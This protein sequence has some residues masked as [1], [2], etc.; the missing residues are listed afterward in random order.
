MTS[1]FPC[2]SSVEVFLFSDPQRR[3][4]KPVHIYL[5][6]ST[7]DRGT[8]GIAAFVAAIC[9]LPHVSVLIAAFMGSTETLQSLAETVLARYT[10]ATLA[11]LVLVVLF[12]TI[13]GTIAAWLVT[14]TEF[15]GRRLLEIA[16]V[17]PLAFPAYVLAYAYTHVLD[18]P[19]IWS[20][21]ASTV[22]Y[23]SWKSIAGNAA[24]AIY[25][26]AQTLLH[27]KA[28]YCCGL[29][30]AIAWARRSAHG[31][32]GCHQQ[33]GSA[34]SSVAGIKRTLPCWLL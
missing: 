6:G 16:L 12:S 15:W 1:F 29:C 21:L 18:H 3:S 10:R 30:G 11:L 20:D 23:L 9:L 14:T 24:A 34:W 26:L 25:L 5:H 4:S 2:Q 22:D 28:S 7:N 33:S 8:W 32:I 13:I 27:R 31:D 19:R 17:L